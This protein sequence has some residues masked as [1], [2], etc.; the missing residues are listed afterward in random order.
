MFINLYY[1]VTSI[2]LFYI[3][4]PFIMYQIR[5]TSL[6]IQMQVYKLKICNKWFYYLLSI[7]VNQ[8]QSNIM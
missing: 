3:L 5:K 6:D 4:K 1:Y 8:T 2:K 7:F